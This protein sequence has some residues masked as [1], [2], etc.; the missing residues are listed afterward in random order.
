MGQKI[1]SRLCSSG[2]FCPVCSS[3][4]PKSVSKVGARTPFEKQL[5]QRIVTGEGGL[6]QRRRMAVTAGRIVTVRVFAGIEQRAH[7]FHVSEL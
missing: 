3:T 5:D 6:M 2:V 1:G 4:L 7:N